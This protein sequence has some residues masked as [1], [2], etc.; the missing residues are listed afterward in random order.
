[1]SYTQDLIQKKKS[2]LAAAEKAYQLA[3]Q[4][5]AQELGRLCLDAGLSDYDNTLLKEQLSALAKGLPK[6]NPIPS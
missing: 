6:S 2:A 3:V 4:K 5:R 1:M